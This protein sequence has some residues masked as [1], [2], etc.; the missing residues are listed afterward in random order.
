[1]FHL[2]VSSKQIDVFEEFS[3]IFT[4]FQKYYYTWEQPYMKGMYENRII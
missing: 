4:Y 2:L 3:S 1:M